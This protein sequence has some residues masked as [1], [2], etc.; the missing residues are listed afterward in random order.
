MVAESC[1]RSEQQLTVEARTCLPVLNLDSAAKVV[2]KLPLRMR[3]AVAAR[4]SF[5][6]SLVGAKI[7]TIARLV[8]L[9]LSGCRTAAPGS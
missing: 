7:A 1:S 8:S 6:G 3:F 9:D 2:R 4:A 5:T